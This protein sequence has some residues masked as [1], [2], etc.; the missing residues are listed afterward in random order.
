LTAQLD[1]SVDMFLA[2]NLQFPIDFQVSNMS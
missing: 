2:H 1:H